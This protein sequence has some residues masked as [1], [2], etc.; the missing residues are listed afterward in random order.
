MR[1]KAYARLIQMGDGSVG[2]ESSYDPGLVAALKATIPYSDRRWDGAEKM[3]RV[4]PTHVQAL[5]N[6]SLQHL[7]VS[8]SVQGNLFTAAPTSVTELIKLEYLGLAKDR[9]GDEPTSSGYA[10][11][12]WSLVFPV[13]AL[14]AWF[15]FGDNE[16]RPDEA[17]T[18]YSVLGAR[19]N[20]SGA[21]IKTA[22]RR[23][24]RTWHPD[25][26]QEPDAAAQFMRI[27]EAYEVLS[28]PLKRRKYEAGLALV[29]NVTRGQGVAVAMTQGYAASWWPPLRCGWVLV[30]GARTLGQLRVAKILQW[31]DITNARG[32]TMVSYWPP[33]GNMFK[34]KWL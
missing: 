12:G 34:V 33:G 7:G 26:C 1:G 10:D 14:R 11:G 4:T 27:Q 17:S 18:L 5:K 21:E 13:S 9:G 2:F 16:I 15:E 32:Q 23:A 24:A 28:D 29:A 3:W 19:R 25:V 8:A 22:Y 20:A 30:E 31:E 6:L